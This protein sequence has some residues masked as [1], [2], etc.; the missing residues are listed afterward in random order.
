MRR[1]ERRLQ[2]HIV[3]V[4]LVLVVAPDLQRLIGSPPVQVTGRLVPTIALL[5]SGILYLLPD[6]R[7][8]PI[9]NEELVAL[10]LS[11]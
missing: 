11:A 6:E 9:T 4:V 2:S 8:A 3:V 7:C 5:Q 10:R 1:L